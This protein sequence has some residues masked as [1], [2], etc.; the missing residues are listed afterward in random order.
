MKLGGNQKNET[1]S[2]VKKERNKKPFNFFWVIF[3]GMNVIIISYF[4]FGGTSNPMAISWKEFSEDL[5][6]NGDVQKV[7]VVDKSKVEVYL[8]PSALKKD[9]YRGVAKGPFGYVKNGPN[10]EFSIG[11]V[12]LFEARMEK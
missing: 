3:L 2:T 4:I 6:K 1:G 8:T 9:K 12:D 7:I 5:L 11:S 10:Y